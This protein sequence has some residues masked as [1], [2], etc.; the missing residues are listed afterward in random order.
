MPEAGHGAARAGKEL[1]T[2]KE[3]KGLGRRMCSVWE[4]GHEP[5]REGWAGGEGFVMVTGPAVGPGV[6]GS[7][8]RRLRQP[9]EGL[10]LLS[11]PSA[12]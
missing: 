5:Q 6:M 11:S 4:R 3:G 12:E 10:H 2:E 1:E 8:K 7:G 9:Q